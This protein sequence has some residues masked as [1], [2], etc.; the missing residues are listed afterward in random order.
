[1]CLEK[2]INHG[3]EYFMFPEYAMYFDKPQ[4]ILYS[5]AVREDDFRVRIDDVQHFMDGYYM[6]WKNFD[7][8]QYYIENPYE[9]EPEP[10]A[11]PEPES[12]PVQK[13]AEE[14]PQET[15]PAAEAA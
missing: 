13:P 9:P 2:R 12:E 6:Y 4:T 5:F 8:I 15:A 3:L 14:P 11:E 1:M 7:R 10:E